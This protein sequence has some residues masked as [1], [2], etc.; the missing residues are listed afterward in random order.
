MLR[1][2]R[3]ASDVDE[4]TFCASWL[5]TPCMNVMEPVMATA[6]VPTPKGQ[7]EVAHE[8]SCSWLD[9]LISAEKLVQSDESH[10]R[11]RTHL[12]KF[13]NC[14]PEFLHAVTPGLLQ[15]LD[16]QDA[17]MGVPGQTLHFCL[18]HVSVSAARNEYV[19]IAA[20][21]N[22]FSVV[23]VRN[24]AIVAPLRIW[25][26]FVDNACLPSSITDDFSGLKCYLH[27][28]PLGVSS[29]IHLQVFLVEPTAAVPEHVDAICVLQPFH[30]SKDEATA[31]MNDMRD[32]KAAGKCQLLA[33]TFDDQT[34]DD[35]HRVLLRVAHAA[36]R[37]PEV[38]RVFSNVSCG[39]KQVP[40]LP[41][42]LAELIAAASNALAPVEL[43][44]EWQSGNDKGLHEA[45]EQ[46][47]AENQVLFRSFAA[48]GRR[49]ASFGT[50]ASAATAAAG[51]GDDCDVPGSA[52]GL[53][54]RVG[55]RFDGQRFV[56]RVEPPTGT[57][58]FY[59]KEAKH[60][61]RP[62]THRRLKGVSHPTDVPLSEW[63]PQFAASTRFADLF[64]PSSAAAASPT[65]T[66]ATNAT[67]IAG[68]DE[69]ETLD[70]KL[71]DDGKLT[72]DR[73]Y[74]YLSDSLVGMVNGASAAGHKHARLVVGVFDDTKA[75]VGCELPDQLCEL[76]AVANTYCQS[77]FPTVA[78]RVTTSPVPDVGEAKAGETGFAQLVLRHHSPDVLAL[79]QADALKLLDGRA[80]TTTE[81]EEEE[82][83]A[84]VSVA[85][86][87]MA[88][89]ATGS[90]GDLFGTR[91]K[92]LVGCLPG[93]RSAWGQSRGKRQPRSSGRARF[94]LAC[95][96]GSAR[97]CTTRCQSTC[98]CPAL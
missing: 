28:V 82:G 95:C 51:V 26:T 88:V 91:R 34:Q 9:L 14:P 4:E 58:T 6:A 38:R 56:L 16:V 21:N 27:S 76:E 49:Q 97:C 79:L 22:Q 30:A 3:C 84:M 70:F 48:N 46:L 87:V 68:R 23:V 63:A 61:G 69:D 25:Q 55:R 39:K 32:L 57:V 73:L 54:L 37:A 80:V 5:C 29:T 15:S 42:Q 50:L 62:V 90:T 67:T 11:A 12:S 1:C 17:A 81:E 20:S 36:S 45:L 71:P 35:A 10:M 60:F 52:A 85:V 83:V 65:T 78:C 75:T 41:A 31:A 2:S 98:C 47:L 19:P 74:G 44:F 94:W 96:V 13:A 24:V 33:D 18:L 53:R 89:V 64:Q 7:Q 72:S 66:A 77:L 43:A 92:A 59:R 8:G 86:L 40:K 93:S